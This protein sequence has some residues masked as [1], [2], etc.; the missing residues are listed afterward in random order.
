MNARPTFLLDRFDL[1]TLK[2]IEGIA[3]ATGALESVLE[4]GFLGDC[5]RLQASWMGYARAL[6]LQSAEIDEIDVIS[7]AIGLS[8]PGRARFETLVDPFDAFAP[9][10]ATLALDEDRHWREELPFTPA[11]PSTFGEA[12]ILLRAI[13]ILGQYARS[14]GETGA[15]LHLPLLLQRMGLT[16]RP[17]PCLVAGDKGFRLCPRDPAAVV[18]RTLRD[19]EER[20][21]DG[22]ALATDLEHQRRRWLS[23]LSSERKPGALRSLAALS[24]RQPV[25]R[26]EPLGQQLNLTRSG[27]GK[28]LNRAAELGLLQE[29]SGRKSWRVYMIPSL[30]RRLGFV[31]ALRGRPAAPP[32][33]PAKDDLGR[34]LAAFDAE[35]AAFTARYPSIAGGEDAEESNE[36]V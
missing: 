21:R 24:L 4:Q 7:W 2:R 17:L 27:A 13:C 25:F 18:E 30:A 20:A 14:N 3:Q 23:I 15:W 28:L 35:M 6:A 9:W 36:S 33:L 16:K 1:G 26:P 12:P 31:P 11:L 34:E 19:L 32:P 5:W 8:I 10:H 29:V 22:V